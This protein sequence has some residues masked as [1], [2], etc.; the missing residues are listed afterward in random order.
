MSRPD[1]SRNWNSLL[2]EDTPRLIAG[3]LMPGRTTGLCIDTI[4]GAVAA[5]LGPGIHRLS[6]MEIEVDDQGQITHVTAFW[7]NADWYRQ[8]GRTQID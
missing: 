6:G 4:V 1:R 3:L 2:N 5:R 8:L 7:D